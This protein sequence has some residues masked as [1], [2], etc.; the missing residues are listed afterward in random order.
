MGARHQP[1]WQHGIQ[2]EA[3]QREPEHDE[4]DVAPLS[5]PVGRRPV[6]GHEHDGWDDEVRRALADIAEAHEPGEMERGLL[7]GALDA[8]TGAAARSSS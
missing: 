7:D 4:K 5:V 2:P 1:R 8:E 3:Q 6:E